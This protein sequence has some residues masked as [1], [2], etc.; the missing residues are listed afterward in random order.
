VQGDGV[1]HGADAVLGKVVFVQERRGRVG[2]VDFEAFVGA[3]VL[4]GEAQ[5]VED[6]SEVEQFRI[7]AL[8]PD[9]ALDRSGMLTPA[10]AS[11]I[12]SSFPEPRLQP[13]EA[14]AGISQDMAHKA[15][16]A[17]G[18][19]RNAVRTRRAAT[20]ELASADTYITVVPEVARKSADDVA[21]L[22][23]NAARC[24]RA[25]DDHVDRSHG[26]G[27]KSRRCDHV[28]NS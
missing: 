5:V 26:R 14:R 7:P 15:N 24:A 1:P 20:S 25:H 22:V 21:R 3:P 17:E 19:A 16:G 10:M 8:A 28:I 27:R 4:L 23:L 9:V 6:R 2:A 13:D 18:A 12:A 11:V